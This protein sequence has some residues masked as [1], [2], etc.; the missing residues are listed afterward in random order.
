LLHWS[1]QFYSVNA[2]NNSFKRCGG[3]V[4]IGTL[5]LALAIRIRGSA[6]RDT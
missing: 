2:N 1:W 5:P 4:R 6:R 3:P